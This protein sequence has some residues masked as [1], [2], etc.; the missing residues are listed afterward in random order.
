MASSIQNLRAQF[1][2]TCKAAESAGVNTSK[3]VL[4]VGSETYGNSY[5]IVTVNPDTGGQSVISSFGYKRQIAM[6]RLE[7]MADAY[8]SVFDARSK[9]D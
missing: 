9:Q 1:V 3:W 5:G 8:W 4:I 2:R 6:A 7:G